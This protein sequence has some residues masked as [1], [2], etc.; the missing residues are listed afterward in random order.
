MGTTALAR[1][2]GESLRLFLL[3]PDDAV[4]TA[5][6]FAAH[7]DRLAWALALGGAVAEREAL[8]DEA[9]GVGARLVIGPENLITVVAK[10]RAPSQ[11]LQEVRYGSPFELIMPVV[12]TITVS[13][14]GLFAVLYAVKRMYGF[15][16]E[17]RTH[18]A[19]LKG[20]L[21]EAQ[22]KL[23]K[24]EAEG[25]TDRHMRKSAKALGVTLRI[26]ENDALARRDGLGSHRG[27]GIDPF[28]VGAEEVRLL[29]EELSVKM[30]DAQWDGEVALI[31]DE[32]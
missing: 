31:A 21:L 23:G 26:D 24:A 4:V 15:D 2:T 17:L 11:P 25:D 13:V 7:V 3:P 9:L 6:V 27:S 32:E 28:L 22:K 19:M 29:E 18:R 5:G 14:P 16:V 12:S 8:G 30:P 10:A 1:Y 20:R